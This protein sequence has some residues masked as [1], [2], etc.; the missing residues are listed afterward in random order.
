MLRQIINI[1]ASRCD[2]CGLCVT[3]CHEGAIQLIDG[4][5]CL[6]REDFCDG[7][8]DC[9]P[10]CPQN[11]ITFTEREAAAYD[12]AAVYQHKMQ[13]SPPTAS[14]APR[15]STPT[16][17]PMLPASSLHTW[18]VQ[19]KLVPVEAAFFSGA[20]LLIAAD[21]TA[22]AYAGMHRDF[23]ADRVTLIGC[24][25]LDATEYSVKLTQILRLN[26]IREVT[27]VRME[28]PCCAGI[29]RSVM[30]ALQNAGRNIPLS[31]VVITRDGR[32]K[33]E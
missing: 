12:S 3:A 26:T 18:P 16:V 7:F 8:G 30:T 23:M 20:S 22:Y 13:L 21:C 29:V 25:K 31:V 2:G 33:E 10:A 6:V 32:M 11:A 14:A 28:V 9:L 5:A 27:V 17:A 19:I 4:K 15:L 1:D 24:P